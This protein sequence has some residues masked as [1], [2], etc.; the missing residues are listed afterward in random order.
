[1]SE[2]IP[3]SEALLLQNDPSAMNLLAEQV[4]LTQYNTLQ[5]LAWIKRKTGKTPTQIIKTIKNMEPIQRK[6]WVNAIAKK[7]TTTNQQR[8][9]QD[10][11]RSLAKNNLAI[12]I[13]PSKQLNSKSNK[14]LRAYTLEEAQRLRT[15]FNHPKTGLYH[16]LW[17][18]TDAESRL[19]PIH[20]HQLKY[21]Q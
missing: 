10:T 15:K 8:A 16:Q 14:N 2:E 9:I 6:H 19:R 3:H 18:T 13:M 21:K 7:A 17:V 1:M 11:I 4:P 20:Q 12:Q 5:R